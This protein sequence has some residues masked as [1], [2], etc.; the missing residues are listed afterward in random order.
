MRAEITAPTETPANPAGFGSIPMLGSTSTI[1]KTD[2]LLTDSCQEFEVSGPDC[3]PPDP[4]MPKVGNSRKKLNL[5][6]RAARLGI[7][8]RKVRNTQG[9]ERYG[10]GWLVIVPAK[11]T[12]GLRIRKQFKA[13]EGG[14]A[15]N[16]AEGAANRAKQL[17]QMAFA[18]TVAQHADAQQAL[19]ILQPLGLTLKDAARF[20]A[21]HL[22]PAGGDITFAAL[23]DRIMGEKQRE[24]LRPASL[25]GL[26][27]HF[28]VLVEH[29]GA[30][31]LVKSVG[32][33]QL[34]QWADSF[35]D[36]GAGKRHVRNFIRYAQQFFRYALDHKFVGDNPAQHLRAPKTDEKVPVVLKIAETKRL[37]AA[38]MLP[39]HRDL[40]PAVV[41]GL[42]CGGARSEELR[43]LDWGHVNLAE[44]K[45]IVPSAASKNRDTR[46]PEIPAGAVE[47]LL[48]HAD[49]S[50]PITPARFRHRLTALHKAAGFPRWKKTHSN[51]RRHSFGSYACKLHDAEWVVDQMGN[52]VRIF[53]RHYKDASVTR[54][55][56]QE[57]F[58]LTPGN[59]GEIAE[60]VPFASGAAKTA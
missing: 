7:K 26:R 11:V 8:V 29:F 55:Q 40:L 35:T 58:K 42:F 59:V 44:R 47:F 56:A 51:A 32:Y 23:R 13:A 9:G 19:A 33:D 28:G 6:A 34:R 18:L 43:R 16:F 21:K 10:F 53:L 41:I 27:F 12:G 48:L 49:R 46:Y 30:D 54:E 4:A 39:E 5:S 50:G 52:S 20:A 3:P 2:K 17:G 38:A 14:A 15:V 36:S 57:Y 31:T 37:L 60:P 25:Q 24:A 22:R 45:L 1:G